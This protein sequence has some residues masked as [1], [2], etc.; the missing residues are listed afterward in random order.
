MNIPKGS[1]Y[2]YV[3]PNGSGK[4]TTLDLLFAMGVPDGGTVQM[5]GIDAFR[6]EV[7]MKRKAAYMPTDISYATW[8]VVWKA[9]RFVRGF[10][11]DRW[12]DAYCESLLKRFDIGS[13]DKISSLSFGSQT[14]LA[15][16][17][18]LSWKPEI[19]VLDEPST[20]LDALAKRELYAELLDIVSDEERTIL[21]SSHNLADLERFAD[22]LGIIRKGKIIHEGPTNE[23]VDRYRLVK[24]QLPEGRDFES[25]PGLTLMANQGGHCQVLVDQKLVPIEALA[26]RGI[27]VKNQ[28]S[29]N[30][31]D[32][33]V[34]LLKPN[35]TSSDS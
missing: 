22:H 13:H 19:L 7:A 1:V 33:F 3:G 29:L 14:K 20:G 31:E 2:G 16:I 34:A 11:T 28:T 17:L 35:S 30:L 25:E 12:D 27:S 15:L 9:I 21:V 10:H 18:A 26:A 8:G 4:T 23:I 32:L 24:F 5:C 6:D